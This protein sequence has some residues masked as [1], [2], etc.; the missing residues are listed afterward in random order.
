MEEDIKLLKE[1]M[2]FTKTDELGYEY[3]VLRADCRYAIENILNRVEQLEKEN[4]EL[5]HW[6]SEQGCSI[7]EVYELFIPKSVIRE[8]IEEIQKLYEEA[9]KKSDLKEIETMNHNNFKGIQLEGQRRI[10]KELL[11]GK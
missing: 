2:H 7:Q 8:K 1:L 6:K 5:K 11:G 3:F 9:L 4:E 10:L